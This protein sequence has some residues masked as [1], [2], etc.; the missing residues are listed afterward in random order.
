MASLNPPIVDDLSGLALPRHAV[1]LGFS[2]AP[3]GREV[4]LGRRD[5]MHLDVRETHVMHSPRM[6]DFC[7]CVS[8]PR[9]V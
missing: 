1:I 8:Q 9:A 7:T 3:G 2:G 4:L 5:G 6:I